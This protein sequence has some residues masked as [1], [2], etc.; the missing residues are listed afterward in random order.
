MQLVP[1]LKKDNS[2]SK[3][4]AHQNNA[5]AERKIMQ[6]VVR[7]VEEGIWVHFH[8]ACGHM[9]TI[10]KSDFKESSLSSI[11]CWACEEEESKK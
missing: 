8:L 9:L 4:G 2:D 3:S 1:P 5:P 10:H 6:S 7:R 11:E